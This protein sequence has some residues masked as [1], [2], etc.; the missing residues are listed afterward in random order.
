M[1]VASVEETV[2]VDAASP[3]VDTTSTTLGVTA[4]ADLLTRLPIQRDIYSISRL[5]PGVTSDA[6]GPTVYGSSG[7]ENQYIVDGLNVTGVSR[8][9]QRKTL[10]FDFVDSIEVK[11]GGLPAEYGRVTGGTL[12]RGDQVR[13]QRLSRHGLRI[14]LGRCAAGRELDG[15]RPSRDVDDGVEP[16]LAVGLRRNP[17]RLRR[18]RQAV[19][20]RIVRAHVPAPDHRDHPRPHGAG[21]PGNRHQS[22]RGHD[23]RHLRRQD[24]LQA[25]PHPDA[26]GLDSRGSEQA[27]GR[28]LRI[29]GP[30]LTWKGELDTGGPDGAVKYTG[31]FGGSVVVDALYGRHSEKTEFAGAGTTTPAIDDLTVTPIAASGG[32]PGSRTSDSAGTTTR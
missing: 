18:E 13:G 24:H 29:A 20:L 10:N 12:Q 9:Q 2:H 31:A 3:V 11:T 32:F 26:D 5:A 16:R 1:A 27:F 22:A 23:H 25:H 19:V 17:G 7:A 15:G 28:S 21:Q 6:V 8:G 4:K 14:Q 30:E